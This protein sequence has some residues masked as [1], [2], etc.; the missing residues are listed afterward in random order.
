MDSSPS[1]KPCRTWHY[2]D[3]VVNK[4]IRCQRVLSSGD[5]GKNQYQHAWNHPTNHQIRPTSRILIL[6]SYPHLS[7][8]FDRPP[9]SSSSDPTYPHPSIRFD[10]PPESTSPQTILWLGISSYQARARVYTRVIWDMNKLPPGSAGAMCS[11]PQRCRP[12]LLD[13]DK[14]LYRIRPRLMRL[15][16][17]VFLAIRYR[18]VS[19]FSLLANLQ[20]FSIFST[21]SIL[22]PVVSYLLTTAHRLDTLI[23]VVA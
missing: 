3:L 18:P 21:F 6:R 5:C 1:S 11:S 15:D 17:T 7:I 22:N 2:Q 16:A 13:T 9:E 8:K 23:P 12:P 10:H 4:Q 19:T 20:Y 14:E